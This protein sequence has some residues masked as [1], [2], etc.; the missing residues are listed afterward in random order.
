M[1]IKKEFIPFIIGLGIV[2]LNMPIVILLYILNLELIGK[3]ATIIVPFE[4]I[5]MGGTIIYCE[6]KG[7]GN[8]RKDKD[9]KVCY[10][11]IKG[12]KF[13]LLNFTWMKTPI[14]SYTVD[15]KNYETTLNIG[16]NGILSPL[17]INN[18]KVKLYYREDNPEITSFDNI[19]PIIVG[20][21]FIITGI[22]IFFIC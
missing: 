15:R 16:I 20:T 4:C 19:M 3:F 9:Y 7:R 14:V 22:Y 12:A 13:K 18:K 2:C 5:I 17:F 8:E 10:G 11:V 21:A 6:L 1:N